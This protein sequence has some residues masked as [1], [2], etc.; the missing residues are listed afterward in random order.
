[1]KNFTAIEDFTKTELDLDRVDNNIQAINKF[2]EFGASWADFKGGNFKAVGDFADALVI[3]A[4]GIN[5]AMYGGEYIKPGMKLNITIPDGKG[6]AAVELGHMT[7]AAKGIA[8]LRH[9]LIAQEPLQQLQ[10][11]TAAMDASTGNITVVNANNNS[12][13][14]KSDTNN[15]QDLGIDHSEQSGS[16]Y[17]RIDWT[18]W[19]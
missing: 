14:T 17:S 4:N 3:S 15:Y 5:T 8:V 13:N 1:M 19:N 2:M 11:A 12:T 16:W 6:L 9:S 18:P 7:S 10:A